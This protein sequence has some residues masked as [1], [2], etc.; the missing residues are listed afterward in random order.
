MDRTATELIVTSSTAVNDIVQVNTAHV[1]QADSTQL[2]FTS[3][4][5]QQHEVACTLHVASRN[6]HTES[7]AAGSKKSYV[8]LARCAI[9]VYVYRRTC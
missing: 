6:N 2:T 5:L 9:A 7:I 4:R 1:Q 8:S 3:V